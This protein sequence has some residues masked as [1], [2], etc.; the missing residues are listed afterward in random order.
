MSGIHYHPH[1]PTRCPSRPPW[2]CASACYRRPNDTWMYGCIRRSIPLTIVRACASKW[3]IKWS[4]KSAPTSLDSDSKKVSPIL[5]SILDFRRLAMIIVSLWDRLSLRLLTMFEHVTDDLITRS[6]L[7]C[8]FGLGW[9]HAQTALGLGWSHAQTAGRKALCEI[10]A[11]C[12]KSWYFQIRGEGQS[13]LL[14]HTVL[15]ARPL[16]LTLFKFV[17]DLTLKVGSAFVSWHSDSI[18]CTGSCRKE[19]TSSS[20]IERVVWNQS[21]QKSRALSNKPMYG[22]KSELLASHLVKHFFLTYPNRCDFSSVV[23]TGT[24]EAKNSYE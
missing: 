10:V 11:D 15:R 23:R 20:V 21:L 2:Q 3:W 14:T 9:S 5:M 18:A 12:A 24:C 8:A 16:V 4:L 6:A 13:Q 7:G 22:R 1:K 19:E 17:W